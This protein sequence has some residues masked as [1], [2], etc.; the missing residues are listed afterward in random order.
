M[1]YEPS[2]RRAEVGG[3]WY[4][5]LV[6]PSGS[7]VVVIGDVM[8]H[9]VEAA[10]GMG[11]LRSLLRGIAYTTDE[12]PDAVLARTDA[13]MS[14]LGLATTATALV[15]RLDDLGPRGWRL[16]WSNAGHPPP[17]VLRADGRAEIPSSA[18]DML[19][20]VRPETPRS[21]VSTVLAPGDVLVLCTDGLLER[22]DQGV[23]VGQARLVEVLQGLPDGVRGSAQQLCDVVLQACAPG[24]R[25]DDVALVAVRVL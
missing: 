13:A 10:A 22:R 9:D 25:E 6:Q 8:G 16:V 7:P 12:P 20:G 1:R 3:D 14:G 21:P 19:L 2:A 11:Q 23:D 18:H 4:D 17:V 5:V 15:G 24:P